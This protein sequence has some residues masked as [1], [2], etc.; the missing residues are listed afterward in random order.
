MSRRNGLRSKKEQ[1]INIDTYIITGIIKK[2]YSTL[3][4]TSQPNASVIAD[5]D[6]NILTENATVKNRGIK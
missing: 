5:S 1:V 2:V 3:K 6:E 4:K